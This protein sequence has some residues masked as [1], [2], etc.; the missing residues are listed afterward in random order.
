MN[1]VVYALTVYNGELV[2]GGIFTTAGGEVSC[3]WARWGVPEV[4][5]GDLNHDCGV[6]ELD[7]RLFAE[8]WLRDDCEYTGF[9]GEADSN[10]DREVNFLDYALSANNWLVGE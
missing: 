10:Y 3:Y 9:C 7:L 4:Y 6:N 2:A 1:N 5:E 8:Q